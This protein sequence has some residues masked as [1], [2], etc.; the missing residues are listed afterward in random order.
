[1]AIAPLL[2]S[3]AIAPLL[4][5]AAIALLLA[6]AA[7]AQLAPAPNAGQLLK[8]LTPPTAA[9]APGT[10]AVP[11]IVAPRRA[12]A[13]LSGGPKFA[14]RSFRLVGVTPERAQALLPLV[15]RYIGDERTLADVEDAAKDVE[16]ALQ[17]DGL[18]LAQVY[19]PEQTLSD[20]SVTLQVL[21]GRLGDVKLEVEPGVAVSPELMN[22]FVDVL[23]G[24]PLAERDRVERAL[25][26]L[27]DLRGIQVSSVLTPGQK[28]G[29]ADLTVKVAPGPRTALVAEAN[30]G[31]S[32]FTG[33][34]RLDGSFDWLSPTGRGDSLTLRALVSTNGGV[35][36]V[37]GS[38][39]TPVGARGTKFGVALSGLKYKLGSAVFEPLDASG[40]GSAVTLQVLH[41]LLR[42]RNRNLFLQTSLDQRRFHDEVGAVGLDS[43]KGVSSYVTFG[44]VGDWRDTWFGGGISNYSANVISGRLRLDS[45]ADRVLDGQNYQTA[46]H[47]AKLVLT[48]ARLQALPNGDHLY[49]S[50]LAQFASKDL[51]SSEKQSLGG[52]SGVR[53]YP[54][55]DTPSDSALIV[56]WEWRKALAI[57]AWPGDWILGVFGDYGVGR[58]HE[59]PLAVDTD[60]VRTLL[61]HGAGLTYANANGLLVRGWVAVRGG[62]RAQSDDSRARAYVQ[63]SQSF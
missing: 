26:A 28:P 14:V 24:N 53:A 33:R 41:P 34:Y 50:A 27:G 8:E 39:L 29:Q 20:G 49:L 58:Q 11:A 22:R 7:Q 23:R 30:N 5:S 15:Q 37:R 57:E 42:S 60:N 52:P 3:A 38:W 25:F 43:R 12:Q 6:G 51:D 59:S 46:G 47:Y 40:T 44:V 18:F 35:A 17:R 45:A 56:G 54:S 55:A 4:A 32:I 2:A 1:M 36:F 9:P 10:D 61:S 63:V 19:V 16:V 13:P 21:E 31:G 48:G 62:T